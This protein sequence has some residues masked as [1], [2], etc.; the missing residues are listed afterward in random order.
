MMMDRYE[1]I[2]EFLSSADKRKQITIL[3]EL[4]VCKEEEIVAILE[5]DTRVKPK[6]L[7]AW[8]IAKARR[9]TVK[10][11]RE[12]KAEAM[13]A[14]AAAQQTGAQEATVEE[15]TKEEQEQPARV[16]TPIISW[17][18]AGPLVSAYAKL[19]GMEPSELVQLCKDVS[20]LLKMEERVKY[21]A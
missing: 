7:S 15:P 9:E 17:G 12:E 5:Q 14:E 3:A 13:K 2:T 16:R 1:I 8:K 19:R 4:N 6:M 18:G 21:D 10:K 20:T 11:K